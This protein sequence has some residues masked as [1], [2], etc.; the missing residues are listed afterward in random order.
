MN[1]K[2]SLIKKKKGKILNQGL[3]Q[4][5]KIPQYTTVKKINAGALQ[6]GLQKPADWT[7]NI[8]K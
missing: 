2:M 7:L 6:S 8:S 3:Y 1:V 4:R 5:K